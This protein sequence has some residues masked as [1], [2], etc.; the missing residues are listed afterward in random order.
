MTTTTTITVDRTVK[1]HLD[2]LKKYPRESYNDVITRLFDSHEEED[3]ES[4]RETNEILSNP[5]TMRGLAKSMEDLKK[6]RVYD[7]E[8]VE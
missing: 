7:F 3:I 5:E 4:L 8:D 6:G 2:S 1:Q